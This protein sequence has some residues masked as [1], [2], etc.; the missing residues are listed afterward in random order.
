MVTLLCIATAI[1]SHYKILNLLIA[2]LAAMN[3]NMMSKLVLMYLNFFVAFNFMSA[4]LATFNVNGL[5][6]GIKRKSIFNYLKQKKFDIILLQE[7][8]STPKIARL[9][10]ME[11]GTKIEWLHG[12]NKSKGLAILFKKNLDCEIIKSY[13][14]PYGRF[15]FLEA[16]L[17]NCLI[18]L[19][20][21]YAPNV[22]DPHFFSS[23]VPP[24][25]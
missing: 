17:K 15:M 18:A 13:A 5:N 10:E 8:H 12:S 19:A 14:D 2:V 24:N 3:M 25:K 9:W 22:D 21:V 23:Y 20:N 11:W 4:S 7:T 1:K 6:D 16:K